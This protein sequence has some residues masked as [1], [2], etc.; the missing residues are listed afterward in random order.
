MSDDCTAESVQACLWHRRRAR[1]LAAGYPSA[2]GTIALYAHIKCG[3][4]RYAAY[5]ET[6][7]INVSV[8]AHVPAIAFERAFLF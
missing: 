3:G 7:A 1:R 2:F 8:K 5:R 4:R 6:F